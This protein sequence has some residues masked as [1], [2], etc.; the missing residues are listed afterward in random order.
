MMA[1][2][3]AAGIAP[4]AIDTVVIS[5]F[6]PDHIDGLK[7]KNGD[8]PFTN[9]EILVPAPGWSYWMDV[10]AMPKAPDRIKIYFRNARRIVGDISKE[11]RRFKPGTEVAAGIT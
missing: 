3:A 9:P 1:N 10:G 11:V 7:T 4:T 8:K 6:H 2:L 5:H